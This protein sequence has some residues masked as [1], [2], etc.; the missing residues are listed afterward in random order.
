MASLTAD[1]Q[2]VFASPRSMQLICPQRAPTPPHTRSLASC[3][4]S[5][6]CTSIA[7]FEAH[8]LT[9]PSLK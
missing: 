3:S 5:I 8:L 6:H 7:E 2:N 9:A 4:A 1:T